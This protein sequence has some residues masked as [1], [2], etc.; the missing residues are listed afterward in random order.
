[1]IDKDGVLRLGNKMVEVDVSEKDKDHTALIEKHINQLRVLQKNFQKW[2]DENSARAKNVSSL[3]P[4]CD[5]S[6]YNGVAHGL[7]EA[8][9]YIAS[10]L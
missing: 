9:N 7:R 8:S 1:M 3:M 10:L 6:Y 5:R 2:A 4:D